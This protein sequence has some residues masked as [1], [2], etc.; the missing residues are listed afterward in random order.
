M[1]EET[2]TKRTQEFT[3]RWSPDRGSSFREIV[4]QRWNF[5]PHGSTVETEDY[6]VDL[7]AVLILE[8]S[9]DPDLGAGAVHATLASWRLA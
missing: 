1:F 7:S 2:E 4:R 3:L 5:D 8:L 9:I 6:R